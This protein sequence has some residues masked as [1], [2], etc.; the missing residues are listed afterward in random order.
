[1]AAL[2]VS[3]ALL[4][5]VEDEMLRAPLL[6]DQLV[7]GA[8]EHARQ[9]LPGM[10]AVQR[11]AVADLMEALPKHHA[12]MGDYFVRSLRE[13]VQ[14]ELQREA[15]RAGAKPAKPLA[16]A[17]VDEEEV[18][19]DVQLSHS[20]EAIKSVAEYELREL[21]TYTAALVGD[22][23]MARDHNPFRAETFARALWAASQALPMS[24]GLQVSFM[25]YASTPLAQLLRKAYA[26]STSR[27]ESMGVE[28]AAYRTLILPAGSRR[29]RGGES[30]FAPDLYRMRET[31]PAPLD[32][33]LESPISYQGQPGATSGGRA[34]GAGPNSRQ[35]SLAPPREHWTE[36][37]RQ[38]PHRADRQA[39]ELVSRLFDAM[40]TDERVPQDVGLLISRLHGPAMRLALRDPSLLDKGEHPLWKFVNRLGFAAEMSPDTADPERLQLLKVAQ[41]TID[42]LA[43]EPEQNTGLY[44]WA[45]E[46]L[47]QFLDKRL[48][49]RLASLASQVGALQKLE[50]KLCYG[51][52]VPSTMHGTL[53]V[54]QLDTVPAQL[55]DDYA[56]APDAPAQAEGWLSRLRPGDW[57]RIFLQGRWVQAQALWPGERREIWLLGDGGSD[58]TWAVR[59]TAL[60]T[61]HARGLL[62][63]LKQRSIVAAA[64]TRVQ[65]QVAQTTTGAAA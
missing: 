27:L 15:P 28:P 29:G 21:Q 61:L 58:A 44:R 50:D 16:L 5:F 26:A 24:R 38:T 36:V 4:Q 43:S 11:T 31:M 18:A 47:D 14:A 59:R 2:Q 9:S 19:L 35:A 23:D 62:K 65:E 49:R 3:R 63:T 52:A 64:A 45:V 40:Q 42:Q 6:F 17:L 39:I 33:P 10:S 54:P 53:D 25:R 32:M 22:M 56:T 41:G 57:V 8:L 7:D 37:A 51:G 55:M 60:I 13:Q 46:R 1:M 30:T 20:I 34:G 48:T 12:R